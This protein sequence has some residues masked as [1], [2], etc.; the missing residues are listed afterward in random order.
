[1]AAIVNKENSII[2]LDQFRQEFAQKDERILR[3]ANVEGR[4]FFRGDDAKQSAPIQV[5]FFPY[6]Y[7]S[8]KERLARSR[9]RCEEVSGKRIYEING[10]FARDEIDAEKDGYL[11]NN[12]YPRQILSDAQ[13]S[14]LEE[15]AG[16]AMDI[17]MTWGVMI[18]KP[19]RVF[20][21]IANLLCH[22]SHQL[23]A[24]I[25]LQPIRVCHKEKCTNSIITNLLESMTHKNA[26]RGLHRDYH[27]KGGMSYALAKED[28]TL[29]PRQFENG[30]KGNPWLIS[31]I[32]YMTSKDFDP[33]K[34]L[35]TGFFDDNGELK[36]IIKCSHLAMAIFEGDVIHGIAPSRDD[37]KGKR[38]SFVYKIAL[39]PKDKNHSVRDDF[40]EMFSDQGRGYAPAAATEEQK[41]EA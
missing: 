14:S 19:G 33:E 29:F 17:E 30:A 36:H 25:L 26:V 5:Q 32:V 13:N 18:Q 38:V 20:S 7:Q 9:I 3:V 39:L 6:S 12:N 23:Q 41:E 31:V 1:M 34:G 22:F 2:G 37:A 4:A 10:F 16:R 11:D 21:E 27:P 28:G 40:H 8:S 24:E 15:K 35:G